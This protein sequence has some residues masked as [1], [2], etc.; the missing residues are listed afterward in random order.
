MKYERYYRQ[1]KSSFE[2]HEYCQRKFIH[3]EKMRNPVKLN[4]HKRETYLHIGEL[5]PWG[6]GEL[7][8]C[9]EP[10]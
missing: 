1:I 2:M 4:Y 9:S 10:S 8:A 3:S 6:R 7:R 5:G